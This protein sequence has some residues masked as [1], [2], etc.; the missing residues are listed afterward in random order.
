MNN[1]ITKEETFHRI[2]DIL[3]CKWTLA[4]LDA[5]A[6]GTQR[7]GQLERKLDGLTTKVLNERV[8][9]LERYGVI[10]KKTYPEVPP[11]VEYELTTEGTKLVQLL[12]GIRT[13]AN[14]WTTNSPNELN[15]R[16]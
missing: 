10:T 9:K 15:R 11:R 5:I 16:G 1:D 13:L 6:E 3:G 7:P 2:T 8:R 14:E 4:I 12:A